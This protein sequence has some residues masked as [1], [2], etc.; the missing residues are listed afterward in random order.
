MRFKKSPSEGGLR[1]RCN[2]DTV[3]EHRPQKSQKAPTAQSHKGQQNETRALHYLEAQG[4]GLLHKN[5]RCRQGEI[6]LIMRHGQTLVFVE[7]RNRRSSHFGTAVESVAWAKQRKLSFAARHYIMMHRISARRPLRF[8]VI[9][10]T[11]NA[12][13][14][15]EWVKNAFYG[16]E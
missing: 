12:I 3:H 14:P 10:I 8:D 11:D 5:Y 9:G 15:I 16:H 13:Q 6:D 7:V 1:S 4:L 2:T